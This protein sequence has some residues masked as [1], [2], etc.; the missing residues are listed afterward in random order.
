M[1]IVVIAWGLLSLLFP[2][3]QL[4]SKTFPLLKL[5]AKLFNL[6]EDA[7]SQKKRREKQ[8]NTVAIAVVEFVVFC[9]LFPAVIAAAAA[10][11][12]LCL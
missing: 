6:K 10:S 7:F 3:F 9:Q 2:D 1:P 4:L 11:A 5:Q 8:K 12:T